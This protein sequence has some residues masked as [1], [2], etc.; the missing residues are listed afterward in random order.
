MARFSLSVLVLCLF[1]ALMASAMPVK[2]DDVANE[3]D[4]AMQGIE[5]ATKMMEEM[6]EKYKQAQEEASD[7]ANDASA[8]TA[9]ETENKNAPMEDASTTPSSTTPTETTPVASAAA[10]PPKPS[11]THI[12]NDNPFA[13]LPLVG[14]LLSGGGLGL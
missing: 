5:S 8:A 14:G 7:N 3:S 13:N 9:D 12:V 2:R 1:M 6:I 11:K 10:Q 4:Y